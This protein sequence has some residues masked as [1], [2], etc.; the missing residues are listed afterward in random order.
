MMVGLVMLGYEARINHI[1]T[2]LWDP[3]T[4]LNRNTLQWRDSTLFDQI[5][6]AEA[7]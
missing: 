3:G 2:A 7:K 4:F 6:Y 5:N 1:T